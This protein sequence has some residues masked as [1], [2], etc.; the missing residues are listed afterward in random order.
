MCI[1]DR[2]GPVRHGGQQ[3]ARDDGRKVAEEKLVRVPADRVEGCLLYKSDAAD[4]RSSVDLGG[5]RIIQKKTDAKR[6][7]RPSQSGNEERKGVNQRGS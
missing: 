1:R 2:P 7:G 5:R 3:K 6:V 4:E